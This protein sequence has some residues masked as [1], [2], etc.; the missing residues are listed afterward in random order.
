MRRV[1]TGVAYG[2][3]GLSVALMA[4]VGA[5]RFPSAVPAMDGDGVFPRLT[6]PYASDLWATGLLWAAMISGFAGL[7][8]GLAAPVRPRGL[9]AGGLLAVGVLV[10]AP[11][12]GTTDTMDYVVYG[13]MAALG[14]DPHVMTPREF[15][16]TGDRVGAL[17][18]RPW[19]DTPS[20]YG[21]LATGTE[22]AAAVLSRGSATA[23]VLW[24]KVWNAL[25]FLAAA[26][27]LD[28]LAGPDRARRS[29]VHLLWTLNPLL[30]WALIGGAH[31]DGLAAGL[32][33]LGLA[34]AGPAARV[35]PARSAAAGLLLGAAGAVKAP[36]LLLGA[37]AAWSLRRS[38]RTLVALG[39]GAATLLAVAYTVAGGAGIVALARRSRSPSWNTPWQLLVPVFG[40][41]PV[42]LPWLSLVLAA[43]V[44]ALLLRK[45]P[46]GPAWLGPA[47]A[48]C[49]AW[50]VTT[51]VY[52]PWYEALVLPL[53]A[54][55]P[56]TRLDWV[57]L[58]RALVATIGCLPGLAVRFGG[59]W[60]RTGP[61]PYVVPGALS[62]LLVVL[63]CGP[64][65]L[66]RRS[67]PE[68]RAA[69][70]SPGA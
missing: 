51:P 2:G 31:V 56:A 33:V 14:H 28:R 69:A 60:L 36:Y 32:A 35:S 29:R 5:C 61:L 10:A 4:L 15:R 37:V 44:T 55:A 68:C 70:S 48:V 59:T 50:V 1:L 26:L 8:A 54:L 39:T 30:L 62:V 67:A 53:L 27:A 47:L 9:V 49:T 43:V 64:V 38:P 16:A 57:Q 46:P 45:R 52:Y 6:W 34:V 66:R 19:Q 18:P 21:P 58:G 22:W 12:M 42:W 23:T 25:A 65:V 13:R 40:R 41:L 63:L 24:L 11:P 3:V 20:V 7:A 17:A